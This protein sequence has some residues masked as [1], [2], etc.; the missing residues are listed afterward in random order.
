M[1]SSDSR[2][3]G[4]L[5]STPQKGTRAPPTP[6]TQPRLLKVPQEPQQLHQLGDQEFKYVTLLGTCCT[7]NTEKWP[8]GHFR[9]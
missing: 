5:G 4:R 7:L 3:L 1:R 2:S 8:T 6:V 9:D